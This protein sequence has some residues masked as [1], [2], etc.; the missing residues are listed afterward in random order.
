MLDNLLARLWERAAA[1]EEP[2]A[3]TVEKYLEDCT[4]LWR[5]HAPLLSAATEL[6]G[7][8]PTL[9]AAWEKSMQ[10]AASGLAAVI[11][12]KQARG[13]LPATGDPQAQALAIAWMAERNYYMLYTRQH[14][15]AEEEHLP[16]VLAPLILHGI[17]ARLP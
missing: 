14:T 10:T 17:G 13:A 1:P 8:R 7:Q 12:S 16:T 15:N 6:L 4:A 5:Q 9:R 11:A 3:V 2:I